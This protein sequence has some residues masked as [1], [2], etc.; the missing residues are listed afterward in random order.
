MNLVFRR[1]QFGDKILIKQVIKLADANKKTLGFLPATAIEQRCLNSNVF[2]C[3]HDNNV[4]GYI[5]FSHL[6]RTHVIKI[7]HFC[8][9][10]EYRRKN[11]ALNLFKAFKK[12][13][14]DAFYIELSCRDD[15][16]LNDFWNKLGFNIVNIKEGRAIN[17]LSILHQF[18]LP[19]QK[20][21]ISLI[22]DS[23]IR[24]KILLDASVIFSLDFES[25]I[26]TEDNYL[27]EYRNDVIFCIAPVIFEDIQRQKDDN[28][29]LSSL[30][31]TKKF[32]ILPLESSSFQHSC[33]KILT[34]FPQ[35]KE[36]DRK[37]LACA[38]SCGIKNFVT[39][40]KQLLGL[41]N[42]FADKYDVLIQSPSEF[43]SYFDSILEREPHK[44]EILPST[45]GK[46]ID[47]NLNESELCN[48]FLNH[49]DGEKKCDFL[50]I[51][52]KNISSSSLKSIFIG[53]EQ[54][55]FI[56]YSINKNIL[57]IHLLRL[58]K[59]S[60]ISIYTAATFIFK[61]L[62]QLSATNDVYLIEFTDKYTHPDI[63]L[64]SNSYGFIHNHKLSV[65][66]LGKLN[67][68]S[69]FISHKLPQ[70]KL[71][72]LYNDLTCHSE[73]TLAKVDFEQRYFPAKFSDIEIPAYIIP[74]QAS[75]AKDLLTPEVIGQYN[76]LDSSMGNILMN[77]FKVYYTATKIHLSA[78][79]R[80]LWY[81]SKKQAISKNTPLRWVGHIIGCSYL[82]EIYTGTPKEIFKKF[83]KIGVYKWSDLN[84]TSKK[85]TTATIFSHTEIF[86]NKIPY[87]TIKNIV[88]EKM[89]KGIT[90]ISFTS[91]SVEVFMTIYEQG[92][93]CGQSE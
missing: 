75:W 86:D 2:I 7:H 11:I 15:Y 31:K 73:D 89:K 51:F 32:Q 9:Q 82:T 84:K 42:D 61:E 88:Q 19:L 69:L 54:Y 4:V 66:Y 53:G 18:R 28:I 21:I 59:R 90:L 83:W 58:K 16:G 45:Y 91:I 3:L 44:A 74:I 67:E 5:L 92:F 36:S 81:V 57:T 6:K 29:K 13:I 34:E 68:F 47:I 85:L 63:K 87:N 14:H 62:I 48:L 25:N 20:D 39:R 50:N 1:I 77:N 40:D 56:L 8:I 26:L 24:P 17:E 49:P 65:R 55:G 10:K 79:A 38:V 60:K 70:E 41:F 64:V 80:I 43:Y 12:S 23:D 30:A 27:L 71:Q 46:L 72:P 76:L 35:V 37:Q 78:P 93:N 52:H 33:A 22:Q